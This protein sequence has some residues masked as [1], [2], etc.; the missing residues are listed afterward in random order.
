MRYQLLYDLRA[1]RI[2]NMSFFHPIKTVEDREQML[3]SVLTLQT[4]IRAKRKKDRLANNSRNVKYAKIFEPITRTLKDLS[5]TPS[6]VNSS[7]TD[8]IDFDS[9]AVDEHKPLAPIKLSPSDL[10]VDIKKEEHLEPGELYKEALDI[11]PIDKRDDGRFG[12]NTV[13]QEIGDNTF[14]VEG[15]TLKVISEDG[16]E[17]D[18]L[19]DDIDV[20]IILLAR[21]PG[22]FVTLSR[23]G[24]RRTK[25]EYVPAVKRFIEIAQKLNLLETA[26]EQGGTYRS[27]SKYKIIRKANEQ[28]GSGFLFSIKPPPF[29]KKG[30]SFKPSTVVIPSDNK[31]LMRQLGKALAEL[32]AGNT[33]MRNLVVP[34]A[35]EASRKKILPPHLLTSDE[36]TW[37]FA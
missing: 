30:R 28:S 31:G 20:W 21:A 6:T 26:E 29:I 22:N 2:S 11:V 35:Q 37:V 18:F 16:D 24:G 25:S 27:L 5:D 10:D 12:L 9:P 15:D 17:N 1:S 7:K 3:K 32:R 14:T 33:S 19:I 4:Q 8:L 34:L 13:S 23:R 36:E